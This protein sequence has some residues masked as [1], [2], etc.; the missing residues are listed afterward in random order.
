MTIEVRGPANGLAGVVDDVVEPIVRRRQMPAERLDAR[1]MAEIEAVDLEAVTPVG[2]VVL[3]R[4]PSG[5]IAGKTRR[6]DEMGARA[7]QLDPSLV[8]DLDASARQERNLPSE[9][10]GLRTLREVERRARWAQLV[11][12][13]MQ[14]PVRLLA[15]VAMLLLERLSRFGGRGGQVEALRGIHVRGREHRLLAQGP[16]PGLGEQRLVCTDPGCPLLL[17]LCLRE[18]T[19]LDDIRVEDIGR[20]REEPRPL[21]DREQAEQPTIGDDRLEQL[22]RRAKPVCSVVGLPLRNRVLTRRHRTGKG[23][24]RQRDGR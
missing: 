20:R 3:P 14:F 2:E 4:I 16:D 22:R 8:S 9:V 7:Q 23:I 5:R 15:D 12:E 10:G 1:R 21:F 13:R 18:A 19:A 11:V 24:W 17:A 6:D